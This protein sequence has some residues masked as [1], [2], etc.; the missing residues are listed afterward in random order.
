MSVPAFIAALL[1]LIGVALLIRRSRHYF[2]LLLGLGVALVAALALAGAGVDAGAWAAL[3]LTPLI[4]FA[5]FPLGP[6]GG[7]GDGGD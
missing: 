1:A 4:V 6:L 7:D 2:R 5:L 3:V